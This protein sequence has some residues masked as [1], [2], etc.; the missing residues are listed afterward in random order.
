MHISGEHNQIV[1]K[2]IDIP[3]FHDHIY[4]F[5]PHLKHYGFE[6]KLTVFFLRVK[7]HISSAPH[8]VIGISFDK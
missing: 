6:L 4:Y 8:L 2:K 5:F 3:H 7:L 1:K